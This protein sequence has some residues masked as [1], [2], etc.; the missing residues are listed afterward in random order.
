[1]FIA[2]ILGVIL[3][4][5]AL[6]KPEHGSHLLRAVV[7]VA[8]PLLIFVSISQIQLSIELSLV[9]MTAVLIIL[10]TWPAA[11]LIGRRLQLQRPTLG[12][13]VIGPMMMNIGFVY[14]LVMAAWGTEGF[15]FLAL[16]DFGNGLMILTLVYAISCWY[17]LDSREWWP[18]IK[19][20]LT[21]P[22]FIALFLALLVNLAALPI[23]ESLLGAMQEVG[24]W[25]ILL[26]PLALG[27][28]FNIKISTLKAVMV[29]V[30]LRAGLGILI[31][32]LFIELFQLQ[33]MARAV[34]LVGAA[35][36]IG[37]NALVYAAEH[38]LDKGFAA[39]TASISLILG[40]VY[41]PVML[42]YLV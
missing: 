18:V 14:P 28:Y 34:V 33:G 22:P 4:K 26:I 42:H 10:L 16:F 41:L 13:F 15:A 9:P 24:R 3:K 36:P 11:T 23:P 5:L 39:N 7:R 32:I 19:G 38:H 27:V 1:V 12:A 31:G 8:L 2:F 40:L 20:I 25:L 37:F 21:F 17:G 35:A 29:S 30:L 6:L